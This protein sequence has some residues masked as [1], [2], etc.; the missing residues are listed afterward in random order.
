MPGISANFSWLN[1]A[2]DPGVKTII[3]STVAEAVL[4]SSWRT[5][6]R[7]PAQLSVPMSSVIDS[8]CTEWKLEAV[9]LR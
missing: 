8:T 1:T 5:L 3:I 2:R 6:R 7:A 4:K 9:E